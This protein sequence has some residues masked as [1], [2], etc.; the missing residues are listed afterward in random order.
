MFFQAGRDCEAKEPFNVGL[1]CPNCGKNGTFEGEK[2]VK[3]L[4]WTGDGKFLF[5][6]IRKCPDYHCRTVVSVFLRSGSPIDTYPN[7]LIDFDSK[8]IPNTIRNS[9]EEAISCHGTKAYRACALMIRRTLEELC[10]DRG[11][12]GN[13]LAARLKALG[14][15]IVV[16]QSLLDAADE[17]RLLGNDAAHIESKNYDAVSEAEASLA[18]ELAKELL[19]AVYQYDDL[20]GRLKALK[21]TQL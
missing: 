12:K 2:G 15:T 7:I 18:I 11:A 3:D 14:A 20:V 10:E 16:P 17:L 9:L 19:K 4:A 6:G 1:R 5:V 21:R 8:S 13:N